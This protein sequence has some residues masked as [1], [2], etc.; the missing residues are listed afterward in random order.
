MSRSGVRAGSLADQI[1]NLL[2]DIGC[3]MTIGPL[4][5]FLRDY[6]ELSER[7]AALGKRE[8]SGLI[9]AV[10]VESTE[11]RGSAR[12]NSNAG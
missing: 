3:S 9:E 8:K 5:Q 6:R 12:L 1:L 2:S 4:Q 10:P 7:S 11:G